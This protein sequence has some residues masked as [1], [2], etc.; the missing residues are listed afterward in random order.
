MAITIFASLAKK[1]ELRLLDDL[2]ETRALNVYSGY[3]VEKIEE[4]IETIEDVPLDKRRIPNL[5]ELFQADQFFW[6]DKLR[7][8]PMW[9]MY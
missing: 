7:L 1:D 2:M 9:F 3:I 8:F 6:H 5:R 4:A